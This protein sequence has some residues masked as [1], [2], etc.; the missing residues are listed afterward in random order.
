MDSISARLLGL[1][2]YTHKY[3]HS[4]AY[5]NSAGTSPYAVSANEHSASPIKSA[6]YYNS[7]RTFPTAS[8]FST[9]LAKFSQ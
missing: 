5:R 7:P 2:R 9:T 1:A 4:T 6:D 3:H 8:S